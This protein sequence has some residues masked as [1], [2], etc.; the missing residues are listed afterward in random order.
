MLSRE[1][2]Q[3]DQPRCDA[4]LDALLRIAAAPPPPEVPRY[5]R[6]WHRRQAALRLRDFVR[7]LLGESLLDGDLPD[8]LAEAEAAGLFGEFDGVAFRLRPPR[9]DDARRRLAEQL[10]LDYYYEYDFPP[11]RMPAPLREKFE[12]FLVELENA[13]RRALELAVDGGVFDRSLE[14][15]SDLNLLPASPDAATA[16]DAVH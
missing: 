6:D 1:L 13:C 5:S 8:L 2:F 3:T 10:A 4:A 12:T 14:L 15:A 9:P 11:T 16:A 7:D